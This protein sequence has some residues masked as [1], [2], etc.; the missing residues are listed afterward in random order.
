MLAALLLG[1]PLLGGCSLVM[2]LASFHQDAETTGSL[3]SPAAAL[4]P[5][6]DA[7]DWRRAQAALALAVDPQG[8]GQPVNWDNPATRRRGSF[9]PAGDLVLVEGQVCRPFVAT[10]GSSLPGTRETRRNGRACR[11]G[12][13]EWA[14]RSVPEPEVR[15]GRAAAAPFALTPRLPGPAGSALEARAADE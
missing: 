4:D 11:T 7:E 14:L 1:G 5:A 2:P 8:P 13:G 9:A 10:L 6:L 3:A 12:P 15:D